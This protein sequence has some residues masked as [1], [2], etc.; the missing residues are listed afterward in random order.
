LAAPGTP[1]TSTGSAL[2]SDAAVAGLP[3]RRPGMGERRLPLAL[4]FALGGAAVLLLL[5]FLFAGNDDDSAGDEPRTAQHEPST[6]DRDVGKQNGSG[7]PGAA[8]PATPV[9]E[10]EPA[11]DEIGRASCREREEIV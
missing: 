2:A 8:A 4:A 9:H 5:G 7:E 10:S 6:S 3:A 1:L 11:R